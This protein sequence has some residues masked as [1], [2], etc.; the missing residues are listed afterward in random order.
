[1]RADDVTDMLRLALTALGCASA[2]VAPQ[3]R[4][5]SVDRRGVNGANRGANRLT[6]C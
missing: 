3:P 4:L 6:C 2:R 5:L 1:M